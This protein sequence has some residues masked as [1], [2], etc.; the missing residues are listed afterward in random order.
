VR[1]RVRVRA[2]VRVRARARVCVCAS[3]SYLP[4]DAPCCPTPHIVAFV[5]MRMTMNYTSPNTVGSTGLFVLP[6]VR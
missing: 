6:A 1:A 3:H 4:F 2:C 5:A